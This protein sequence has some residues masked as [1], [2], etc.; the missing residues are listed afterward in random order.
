MSLRSGLA[1]AVPGIAPAIDGWRERTCDAKP[2]TGVPPHVTLLFPFAPARE[3]DDALLFA[4]DQ[5]LGRF[6]PFGITLARTARFPG[7]LYLEPEPAEPLRT[8]TVALVERFPEYP[9]YEG[10]F[11]TDLVPHLTVAQGE[12]AVLDAAARDVEPAL[13]FRA[14]VREALLFEETEPDYGAWQL[15]ARFQLRGAA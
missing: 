11:G 2:S 3:V 10:V 8:L 13:P 7:V 4:V 15:R 6:A 9:P 12:D 1:V 14:A 5:L